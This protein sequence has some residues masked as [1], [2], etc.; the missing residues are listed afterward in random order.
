MRKRLGFVSCVWL[1]V[2][3][4]YFQLKLKIRTR[5][6]DLKEFEIWIVGERGAQT[7]S[8]KSG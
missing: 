6:W 2:S 4:L 1:M 7:L 8:F 3:N 5:L